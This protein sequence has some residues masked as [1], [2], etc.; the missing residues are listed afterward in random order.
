MIFLLRI[1]RSILGI[2][3]ILSIFGL[4]IGLL[5]RLTGTGSARALLTLTLVLLASGGLFAGLGRVI[6]SHQAPFRATQPAAP[7]RARSAAGP[8]R[9]AEGTAA[10]GRSRGLGRPW[11]RK[12]RFLLLAVM[13]A[14]VL[15]VGLIGTDLSRHG[16]TLGSACGYGFGERHAALQDDKV[17]SVFSEPLPADRVMEDFDCGGFQDRFVRFT[18][19]LP[20]AQ[21]QR[22]GAA[23]ARTFESGP[24]HARFQGPRDLQ[25]VMRPG[26]SVTTYRLPGVGGLDV[27]TL[28]LDLPTVVGLSH[29]EDMALRATRGVA[30]H[31]H[32]ALQLAKA[33]DAAFTVFLAS[34]LDFDRD[35]SE[36]QSSILE[37]QATLIE[38]LLA[39]GRIVG[40]S[41][42][43]RVYT[44]TRC[45]ESGRRGHRVQRGVRG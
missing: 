38:R 24:S 41:N 21:G 2:V 29:T 45:C 39:L 7:A 10:L 37:V 31:K 26:G 12:R 30:H 18:L 5:F 25:R 42:P 15:A 28:V 14:L 43:D 16:L 36:D 1:V 44:L 11:S 17:V 8:M 20:H 13:V 27:R 23:L 22:L 33:D 9:T 40:D 35:A 32:S 3:F 4:L 19:R 6:D 34:I